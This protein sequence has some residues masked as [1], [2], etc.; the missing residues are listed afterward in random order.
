MNLEMRKITDLK[1]ADYNPRRISDKELEKLK[2]SIET[3]G[4]VEP[5][6]VNG[7]APR[8]NVVISGHQRLKAA[9]A[10]GLEKIPVVEVSLA[11][12][13]EKALN[14]ALNKIRGN[15]DTSKLLELLMGLEQ[16]DEDLMPL[17]GFDEAEIQYLLELEKKEKETIYAHETEDIVVSTDDKYG[18][19]QG[20]I[21][22]IDGKHRILCGDSTDPDNFRKLL[23]EKKLDLV[24]TSPPYNL[25]IRYGKYADNKEYK[26][27]MAM[28]EKVF[29]NVFDYISK[30]G[31]D[32]YVCINIGREWGPF[33][34]AADYHQLLA[35][36]G[37]IFF[38]NI[39]WKK[40]VAAARGASLKNPFPRYYRP[41]VQTEII[42]VY[43]DTD[44][45]EVLEHMLT[46]Q[47]SQEKERVNTKKEEIPAMLLEK[48][49]G[50][51]WEFSPETH[52]HKA[53]PAPCPVQLPF[54]CIRF[55]TFKEETVFDPFLGSGTTILAADQLNRI[56]YGIELDPKYIGMALQRYKEYK[57]DAKIKV[58]SSG[59]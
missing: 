48:Y 41:K 20:D 33:N 10:L 34:V 24:V 50:N 21:V 25:D 42:Q 30:G 57:P 16:E 54:N 27:Y 15:W 56:G 26:D 43:A 22:E 40:P 12:K 47:S 31:K 11:P 37:Y 2:R 45:P 53:R 17:T 9:E 52:L 51:V 38:R 23:G 28:I 32:R 59:N 18:I 46:Y 4:F 44:T 8:K 36:T 3:F 29:Y 13:Q 58:V 49:A 6:V 55:F 1:A 5:V 19:K 14:V 7:K 39:Y 35:K